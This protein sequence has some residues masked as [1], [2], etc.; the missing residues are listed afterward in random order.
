MPGE[1]QRALFGLGGD[2]GIE[3]RQHIAIGQIERLRRLRLVGQ[4]G[5]EGRLAIARRPDR[6]DAVEDARLET[7]EHVAALCRLG[8]VAAGIPMAAIERR[9]RQDIEHRNPRPRCCGMVG[10]HPARRIGLQSRVRCPAGKPA[11]IG[12]GSGIGGGK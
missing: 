9:G 10:G 3:R 5:T 7:Q 4:E 11:I 8:I 12:A 2:K 6:A 1:D